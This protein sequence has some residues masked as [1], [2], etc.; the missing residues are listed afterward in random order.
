M[1]S[2]AIK[3]SPSDDFDLLA[4]EMYHQNLRRGL[5]AAGCYAP[6]LLH[7]RFLHP[8][9]SILLSLRLPTLSSPPLPPHRSR[10]LLVHVPTFKM[11][12]LTPCKIFQQ[13]LQSL[14]NLRLIRTTPSL[15]SLQAC[16]SNLTSV[17]PVSTNSSSIF[18]GSDPGRGRLVACRLCYS[19]M[20]WYWCWRRRRLAG[21]FVPQR[22]VFL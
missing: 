8:S 21:Y 7:R 9:T 10:P 15:S 4:I 1:S 14:P 12:L 16:S 13:S 6:T 18:E 5:T 17:A 2:G 11:S 3:S 20:R 19:N 22:H